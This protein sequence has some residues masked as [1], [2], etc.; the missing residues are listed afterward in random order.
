MIQAKTGNI[1]SKISAL[2]YWFKI[3]TE[4]GIQTGDK[5]TGK[6]YKINKKLK[7]LLNYT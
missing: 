6:Y 2:K 1:F 5:D 7:Q 4:V 3:G